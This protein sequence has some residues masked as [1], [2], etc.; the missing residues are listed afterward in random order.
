MSTL[1]N[2]VCLKNV[3]DGTTDVTRT[4][5][6]GIPTKEQRT[7]YTRVLMGLINLSKLTFPEGLPTSKMDILAR[8]PLWDVLTDYPHGTGHGIGA[9]LSV[10]EGKLMR[11]IF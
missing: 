6:L 7:A 5:H 8:A 11:N 9:Y 4:F 1:Q 3:A 10:H 2:N